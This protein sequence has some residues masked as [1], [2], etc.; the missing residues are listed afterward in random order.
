MVKDSAGIKMTGHYQLLQKSQLDLDG[1]V[2]SVA[3]SYCDLF[4]CW[5]VLLFRPGISSW[6][7]E[8][9]FY[10]AKRAFPLGI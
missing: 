3:L 6:K 5:H 4:L 10:F 1:F 9:N 7:G 8:G 2:G